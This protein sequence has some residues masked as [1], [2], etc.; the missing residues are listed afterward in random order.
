MVRLKREGRAF[1]RTCELTETDVALDERASVT[2][3][4]VNRP[5][6]FATRLQVF[7]TKSASRSALEHSQRGG[8]ERRAIPLPIAGELGRPRRYY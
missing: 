4:L 5:E 6:R 1:P 2:P 3:H 7:N 8:R